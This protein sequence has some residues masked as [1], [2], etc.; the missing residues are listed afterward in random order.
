MPQLAPLFH[1]AFPQVNPPVFAR[2]SFMELWLSQAGLVAAAS[3]TATFIGVG[4]AIF[5]T[6]P[7]GRDFRADRQRA[8]HGRADLSAGRGLALAVPALGFGPRPTLVALFLYGLLPIV[9]NAI[10]GLEGVPA[11]V[12]RRRARHGPLGMAE[13]ARCRI[14]A[15]RAGDPGRCASVG[16][17]RDRHRDDRLDGRRLDPWH[18]DLRRPRR[19]QAAL[20]IEGAVLVALFAILT[21]MLFARLERRLRMPNA[22]ARP[23]P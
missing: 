13:A 1:W 14:A 2:A 7:A 22:D 5:V 4:L 17:D 6:R 23:I 18:P 8:R 20:V 3:L 21:D 16:D 9:E 12:T 11:A 10:A 19:Q 15:R